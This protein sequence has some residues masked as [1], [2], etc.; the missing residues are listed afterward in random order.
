MVF[1]IGDRVV[2]TQP[3]CEINKNICQGITGT[4]VDIGKFFIGVRWDV[5]VNGHSLGGLCEFGYGWLVN[6]IEIEAEGCEEILE[7]ESMTIETIL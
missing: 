4:V 6:E 5:L 2:Y 3:K 7:F 1:E